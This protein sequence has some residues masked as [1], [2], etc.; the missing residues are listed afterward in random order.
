LTA[1]CCYGSW[2][3]FPDVQ[4]PVNST[5]RLLVRVRISLP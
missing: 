2:E 5:V 3:F 4:W 1:P